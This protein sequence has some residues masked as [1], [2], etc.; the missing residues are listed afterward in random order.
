MG[1]S[2]QYSTCM[3]LSVLIDTSVTSFGIHKYQDILDALEPN[4]NN[5]IRLYQSRLVSQFE[6]DNIQQ[7]VYWGPAEDDP[8]LYV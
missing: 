8:I 6:V 1:F 3:F 5:S 2:F 4:L 7:T